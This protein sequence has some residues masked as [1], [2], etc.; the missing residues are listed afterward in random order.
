MQPAALALVT[1]L[2]GWS[3]VLSTSTALIKG[4]TSK[5]ADRL[6]IA[7][8][9]DTEMHPPPFPLYAQYANAT[10]LLSDY[11]EEGGS[12]CFVPGSHLLCRQPGPG[13]GLDRIVPVEA[14][15][16]S[17]VLWHGNT[18][19][20]A[21]RRQTKGLRMAIAFLYARR[22]L[23]TREPYREDV[24][25][26]QLDRN[27]PRFATLM[28]QQ[29]LAGWRCRG[30]RL[31]T[32]RHHSRADSLHLGRQIHGHRRKAAPHRRR[33]LHVAVRRPRTHRRQVRGVRRRDVPPFERLPPLRGA[34]PGRR[35]AVAPRHVV[36]VHHAGVRGQGA[37]LGR[38]ARTASSS[39]SPSATSSWPERSRSRRASPRATP[40]SCASAWPMELVIVPFSRTRRHRGP[41]VRLRAVRPMRLRQER[42]DGRRHRRHRHPPL[43]PP[44]RR[45]R[46][47]SMGAH[48]GA[49]GRCATPG[50]EWTDLQFAVRRQPRGRSRHGG[51]APTRWSTGSGLTGLQFI[52]VKNGCATGGRR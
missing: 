43:R 49:P 16:G 45:R 17:L 9:C 12:L 5:P 28:G 46:A 31:L 27:P 21:Y 33:P 26:E 13:E 47:S 11:S 14:P 40:T 10:W 34:E 32:A 18:W 15:M 7:L 22:F 20:G 4:P 2:L 52:N 1:K 29:I 6:D 23:L 3:C 39:P 44:R 51:R 8:H 42:P 25:K 35:R 38:Q 41:D 19:H 24:T 37:V 48:R 36:D 50:V 30:P